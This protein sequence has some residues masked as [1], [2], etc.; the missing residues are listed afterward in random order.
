MV[1]ELAIRDRD[2]RPIERADPRRAQADLLDGSDEVVDLHEVP[3]S[4]WLI[5]PDRHRAEQVLDRLLR[6]EREHEPADAES[7]DQAG[8]GHA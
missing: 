3:L 6:R 8:D 5:D 4:E 7:C 2:D 1:R